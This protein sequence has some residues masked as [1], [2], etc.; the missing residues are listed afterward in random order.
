MKDFSALCRQH[1]LVTFMFFPGSKL[2]KRSWRVG[3]L[4]TEF[5]LLSR[6]DRKHIRETR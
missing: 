4:K 2:N 5:F 3:C 1:K 6:P